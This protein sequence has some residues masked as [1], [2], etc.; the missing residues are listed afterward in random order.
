MLGQKCNL[1][2]KY[3]M[4]HDLITDILPRQK[5]NKDIITFIKNCCSKQNTPIDIRFYGGEPLI[6]YSDIKNIVEELKLYNVEFSI[7]TNGK[8]LNQE[9]VDFF[10]NDKNK[11]KSCALSWDGFN[12]SNTRKYDIMKEKEDLI[13]QI[14]Q[15]C[16]SGVTSAY[17]YPNDF[18]QAILPCQA[19]YVRIHNKLFSFISDEIVDACHQFSDLIVFDYEYLNQQMEQLIRSMLNAAI[20]SDSS[21]ETQVYLQLW[22]TY[23]YFV[24]EKLSNCNESFCGNGITTLNIDLKGHLYQCHNNWKKIGTIYD[25]Y[26]KYIKQA[27]ILNEITNINYENTCKDCEVLSLCK[28]GC[29]LVSQ[30]IRKQTD[31]C[32]LRKRIFK[33]ILNL[34]KASIENKGNFSKLMKGDKL[35]IL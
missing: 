18:V 3:C 21:I 1:S 6:Y 31:F 15:L 25:S 19:K 35:S 28:S 8:L 12:V 11:F 9:I 16:I 5:L 20:K 27:Q 29:P 17:N 10:N 24:E 13:L 2:C 22:R 4:Q 7:I 26:D 33:P 30:E 34:I 32:E 14:K 23:C